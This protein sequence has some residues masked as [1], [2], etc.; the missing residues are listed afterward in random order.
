MTRAG[1]FGEHVLGISVLGIPRLDQS[2]VSG[3]QRKESLLPNSGSYPGVFGTIECAYDHYVNRSRR[4]RHSIRQKICIPV[5]LVS[6]VF[7]SR[8]LDQNDGENVISFRRYSSPAIVNVL[9][10]LQIACRIV[11]YQFTQSLRL[12]VVVGYYSAALSL[13][14]AGNKRNVEAR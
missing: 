3:L 10:C 4:D 6:K 11:F 12:F 1:L 5:R 9:C 7:F 2:I 13:L 14:A 8:R